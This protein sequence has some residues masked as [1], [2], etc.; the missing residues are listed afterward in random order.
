MDI[1]VLT[2]PNYRTWR[3]QVE[4]LLCYND[5]WHVV[6]PSLSPEDTGNE[7]AAAEDLTDEREKF[8][9]NLHAMVLIQDH[10]SKEIRSRI[11]NCKDAAEA[12][13]ELKST[14]GPQLSRLPDMLG[15]FVSYVPQAGK[16]VSDMAEDLAKLQCDIAEGGGWRGKEDGHRTWGFVIYRC[17]YDSDDDWNKFMGLLRRHIR[18]SFEFYNRL[19]IM[20]SLSLTIIEDKSIFDDASTSFVRKHFKQWAATA[21][22][23]EQGVGIGPG[24]SQRYRYCI[25]VDD[26][27]LE[28]IMEDENDGYVNLIKME[29]DPQSQGD[30]GPVEDPIE[31]CT[32]QDIGCAAIIIGTKSIGGLQKWPMAELELEEIELLRTHTKAST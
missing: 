24:L 5:V 17:T 16:R 31:D 2:G 20:D 7:V 6:S 22:E 21:P 10:C 23:Q 12:W 27:A 8:R 18:R 28:S 1:D 19:D 32:L 26:Y 3:F 14:Y 11:L 4:Y 29:W 9:Q 13:E 15:E 30:R 25:Q